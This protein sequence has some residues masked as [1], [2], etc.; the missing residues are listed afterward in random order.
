MK[1]NGSRINVMGK[2]QCTGIPTNE[3]YCGQWE[4]GF[5]H[6]QGKHIWIITSSS[7]DDSQVS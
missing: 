7:S 5:Q 2:E 6:G 4:F 1:E 3:I